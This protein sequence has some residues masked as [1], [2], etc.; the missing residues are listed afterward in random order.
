MAI[1]TREKRRRWKLI[2]VRVTR[3]LKCS[4]TQT[5][6]YTIAES[7]RITAN[8]LEAGELKSAWVQDANATKA[9]ER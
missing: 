2:N 4:D 6:T 5:I 1:K 7:R 9:R 8:D 3:F